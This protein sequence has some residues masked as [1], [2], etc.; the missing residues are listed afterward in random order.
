METPPVITEADGIQGQAVSILPVSSS[1]SWIAFA[2]VPR[3]YLFDTALGKWT[4]S[5]SLPIAPIQRTVLSMNNQSSLALNGVFIGTS[6][7]AVVVV[8][9]VTG[10]TKATFKDAVQY[11]TSSSGNYDLVSNNDGL[12]AGS[13]ASSTVSVTAQGLG[14][15]DWRIP[16]Q[17]DQAGNVWLIRRGPTGVELLKVNETS[18]STQVV[19]FVHATAAPQQPVALLPG[20]TRPPS[21]DDLNPAVQALTLDGQGHIWAITWF[22]GDPA[23]PFAAAYV[24]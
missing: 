1:T 8:D 15:L 17:R 23:G 21:A 3:L 20:A 13:G 12:E 9:P 10:L 19:P 4:T 7:P 18:G 24:Y 14:D 22:S 6:S 5:L 11:V 16:P 2:G